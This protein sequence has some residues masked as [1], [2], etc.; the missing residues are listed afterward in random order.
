MGVPREL[1][2]DVPACVEKGDPLASVDP[3]G[4][5]FVRLFWLTML[6]RSMPQFNFV[7]GTPALKSA[8]S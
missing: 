6:M 5:Y 7:N 1:T 2:G 8:A 3:L 4:S